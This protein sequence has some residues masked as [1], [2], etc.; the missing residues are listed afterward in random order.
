[1][2]GGVDPTTAGPAAAPRCRAR[3]RAE[4]RRS[5]EP[6][7]TDRLA[8]AR[9]V[10]GPEARQRRR[11]DVEIVG[12]EVSLRASLKCSDATLHSGL[13]L[14][15]RITLPHFSIS[16]ATSLPSSAGVAT[17][18]IPPRSAR[19][20]LILG[21]ARPALISLFSLSITSSAAQAD[22][23]YRCGRHFY[24]GCPSIRKTSSSCGL[25]GKFSVSPVGSRR[26]N[27][28]L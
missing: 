13:M 10:I 1:A 19:R 20:A 14:A 22:T 5:C 4:N 25:I 2:A 11:P 27:H 26:R 28:L 21:S 17:N 7:A 6:A 15:A 8:L 16:S 3:C 12:G 23:K 24:S 18:G 9:S